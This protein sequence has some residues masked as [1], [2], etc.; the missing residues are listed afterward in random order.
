VGGPHSDRGLLENRTLST[1]EEQLSRRA[2]CYR[3]DSPARPAIA[4]EEGVT[5]ADLTPIF[6]EVA[7]G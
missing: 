1:F 5:R 4:D 6:D 2:L 3:D 7:V